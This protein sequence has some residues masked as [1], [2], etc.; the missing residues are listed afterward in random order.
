MKRG[1]KTKGARLKCKDGFI[2]IDSQGAARIRGAAQDVSPVA[3]LTHT[4]YRYPA[5]FSPRFVRQIIRSFTRPG[6]TVLDPFMGGGT[7]LVEAATLGRYAVGSDISELATFIAAVKTALY[8]DEDLAQ[9]RAWAEGAASEIN[10]HRFPVYEPNWDKNGYLKHLSGGGTWRLGK[11]I[12][13]TL[14]SAQRLSNL[15]TQDFAR[16]IVLRTAQW[17]LDARKRLPTVD[18]FR[19]MLLRN[20]REM[21][22]GSRL[23]ARRVTDSFG[24]R[25]GVSPK[26][27]NVAAEN[28]TLG[29]LNGKAA[30][31][32]L[33]VTSPPYPGIHVLYHR[34]QVDGRKETP[35]PFWIANKLDGT[36]AKYYT[37]GDRKETELRSYFAKLLSSFRAVRRLCKPST[38]LVQMVAF[39]EPQWQLPRY[40]ATMRDA[41]FAEVRIRSTTQRGIGRPRRKVPNRRWHADQMGDTHGSE[42]IV[43]FH[44]PGRTRRRGS[45]PA[46][47]A[48]RSRRSGPRTEPRTV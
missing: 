16:C 33:I 4:F 40:L 24:R 14:I 32:S 9:V 23:Y 35:A 21:L 43:L 29:L 11:A 34:W 8:V 27:L 20:A 42:E 12:Q 6:D 36:G 13:Q 28:L 18:D 48:P 17:A 26:C 39:T 10:I 1:P 19:R 30:R 37:M 7:T 38:V 2:E 5:R 47:D 46:I 31:P 15:R 41:G 45:I 25:R 44:V 22:A 3:G